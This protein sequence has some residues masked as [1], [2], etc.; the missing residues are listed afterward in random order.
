MSKILHVH[1]LSWTLINIGLWDNGQRLQKQTSMNSF[2][3][4]AHAPEFGGEVGSR[5]NVSIHP[6]LIKTQGSFGR[7]FGGNVDANFS[8]EKMDVFGE[9][10]VQ[11][12]CHYKQFIDQCI[13]I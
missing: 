1:G 6:H 9:S 3:L 8:V 5:A 12:F 4:A 13:I 2:R 7:V 10:S 11:D